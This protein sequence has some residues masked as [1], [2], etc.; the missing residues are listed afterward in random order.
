MIKCVGFNAV[1]VIPG[2]LAIR[3]KAK[4]ATIDAPGLMIFLARKNT[5]SAVMIIT[6]D[7]PVCIPETVSP[8]TDMIAAYII[9][10]PGNFMVYDSAYGVIPWRISFP[11]AAYSPSS[12]SRGIANK[13]TRK[14]NV[15]NNKTARISQ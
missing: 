9:A 4:D 8:K 12:Q 14:I 13:C 7:N 11:M 15:E 5:K 10:V 2:E 3:I 1:P 6:R